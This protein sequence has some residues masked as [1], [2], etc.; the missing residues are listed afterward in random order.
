MHNTRKTTAEQRQ[1]LKIFIAGHRDWIVKIGT[2]FLARKGL[3]VDT[4]IDSM[5]KPGFQFDEIA[6]LC[7]AR[8][9]H[10]HILIMMEGR[11]W[12]SR[13]DNDVNKYRLRYAFLGNLQFGRVT[14]KKDFMA[15]FHDGTKGI[16]VFFPHRTTK[17]YRKHRA[18]DLRTQYGTTDKAP[19]KMYCAILPYNENWK[20]VYDH[21]MNNA[22]DAQDTG[23]QPE[24]ET[25]QVKNEQSVE[26]T[27]SE[28]NLNGTQAT[29][30]AEDSDGTVDLQ[31]D[32][33]LSDIDNDGAQNTEENTQQMDDSLDPSGSE[34]I[35]NNNEE[36]TNIEND[37]ATIPNG[38][39]SDHSVQREEEDQ[40]NATKSMDNPLS[41]GAIG[42]TTADP[43]GT[44]CNETFE[45]EKEHDIKSTD[46]PLSTGATGSM[47]ADPNGTPC[48]ETVETEKEDA[49]KSMDNPHSTHSTEPAINMGASEN[50]HTTAPVVDAEN[51]DSTDVPDHRETPDSTVW[52]V[53]ESDNEKSIVDNTG[54][55]N[56]TSSDEEF[57]G[58]S[59]KEIP[60]QTSS[61]DSSSYDSDSED[62]STACGSDCSQCSRKTVYLSDAELSDGA[63]PT[64]KGK[65]RQLSDDTSSDSDGAKKGMSLLSK[66]KTPKRKHFIIDE[67]EVDSDDST[68]SDSGLESSSEKSGDKVELD[69]IDTK[70]TM[71]RNTKII[72]TKDGQMSVTHYKLKGKKIQRCKYKCKYCDEISTKQKYHNDHMRQKHSDQ[73]FVCFH[74]QA[75]F[76]TTNGL[77]KHERSHYNLPYACSHCSK[78]FLFPKQLTT[79]MVTHTRRI[80]FTNAFIVIGC[81][82]RI[83][84]CLCMPRHIM[85]SSSV[86]SLIAPPEKKYITPKEI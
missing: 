35:E 44:T 8:M 79:H 81:L 63:Q 34:N 25:L 13:K 37:N 29:E 10:R 54:I 82:P 1:H 84:Q 6:L 49:I 55:P 53:N 28:Q 48:N 7:Y 39:A 11:F 18:L 36:I 78:R 59:A 27:E 56:G 21:A 23:V 14:G 31:T 71:K 68:S 51:Q 80:N 12:T 38:T 73:K 57:N 83:K 62:S 16:S 76:T 70:V 52:T 77:Y 30:S 58:F 24:I 41:T 32:Q 64:K 20:E 15:R 46:N 33:V 85:N 75:T 5:T 86:K 26:D 9:Y 60:T 50:Q 67:A 22:N 2:K 3:D 65:K 42:S 43:N 45:T 40:D 74:C 72:K 17:N 69:M 47:T 61:D 66:S 19:P 4:Y